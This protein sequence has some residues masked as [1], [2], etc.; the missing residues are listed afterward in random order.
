MHNYSPP[1]DRRA[2]GA[3]SCA[4]NIPEGSTPAGATGR[5][6]PP[7]GG[8]EG[9]SRLATAAR[10][11]CRCCGLAADPGLADDWLVGPRLAP[12][13]LLAQPLLHEGRAQGAVGGV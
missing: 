1:A 5:G 9:A 8:V 6:C 12:P 10:R 13:P 4:R 3:A 7:P 11:L 2:G